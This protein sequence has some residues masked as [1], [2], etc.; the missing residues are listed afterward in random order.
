MEKI[1]YDGYENHIRIIVY[2][3]TRE[4]GGAEIVKCEKGIYIDDIFGTDERETVLV[5][6]RKDVGSSS[7]D[8]IEEIGKKYSSRDSYELIKNMLA[9]KKISFSE[10]TVC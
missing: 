10:N 3:Q 9:E 5:I 1:I 2:A 8:F 4:D 6:D 7:E